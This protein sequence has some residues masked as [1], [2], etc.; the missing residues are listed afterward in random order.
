MTAAT[1]R[2]RQGRGRRDCKGWPVK[3]CC[4]QQWPVA[5]GPHFKSVSSLSLWRMREDARHSRLQVAEVTA[6]NFI[7]ASGGGFSK[8]CCCFD[9]A[10]G[11][12][13]SQRKRRDRQVGLW[14]GLRLQQRQRWICAAVIANNARRGEIIGLEA[15]HRGR[16]ASLGL[17]ES[18]ELFRC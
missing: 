11:S 18:R 15:D 3:S 10:T 14:V 8:G 7:L 12:R 17:R 13:V 9:A 1:G 4:H 16:R 5:Q 2:R 6:T